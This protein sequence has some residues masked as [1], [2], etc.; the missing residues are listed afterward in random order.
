MTL[1]ICCTNQ[2]QN[3]RYSFFF[4][5]FYKFENKETIH[6]LKKS[7]ALLDLVYPM[8]Y[9]ISPQ[10]WRYL[11]WGMAGSHTV[12]FHDV[13]LAILS[14]LYCRGGVSMPS[15]DFPPHT[16]GRME[17]W[18]LQRFRQDATAPLNHQCFF[19][20]VREATSHQ[21]KANHLTST[22]YSLFW[23]GMGCV[24]IFQGFGF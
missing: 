22:S 15:S 20:S 8:I 24:V 21:N 5:F 18:A 6:K 7:L 14:A 9:L 13:S 19:P 12:V 2:S 1:Q 11:M 4:V 16:Q 3:W 17:G 10:Q 23:D